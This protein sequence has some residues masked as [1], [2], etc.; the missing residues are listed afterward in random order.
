MS[1]SVE[2]DSGW[3]EVKYA[4]KEIISSHAND[5]ESYGP[6]GFIAKVLFSEEYTKVDQMEKAIAKLEKEGLTNDD[7]DEEVEAEEQ[8]YVPKSLKI[9]Q[10]GSFKI[11]SFKLKPKFS[12]KVVLN[13]LFAPDLN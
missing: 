6:M 8:A 7:G 4:G 9:K 2:D 1:I 13:N 10:D 5:I 11:Y 3:A 12:K